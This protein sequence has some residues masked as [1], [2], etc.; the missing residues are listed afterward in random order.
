[1]KKLPILLFLAAICFTI[2]CK[3]DKQQPMPQPSGTSSRTIK[4]VLYTN[5]DFSTD[6]DTISFSLIIQSSYGTINSHTIFDTTLAT[7]QIKDIPGLSNKLIFQKTI[8][9]D[10]TVLSAGFV[11]ATRFGIGWHLDT[12]GVNSRSKVIE[13]P[14]Q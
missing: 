13:Y 8:P 7:M 11:Y 14:F 9:N 1:M 5:Q 4:F 12:V 2:S 3:K 6:D 10:K